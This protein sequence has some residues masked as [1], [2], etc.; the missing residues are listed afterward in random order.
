MSVLA[1]TPQYICVEEVEVEV[2]GDKDVLA[3]EYWNNKLFNEILHVFM[4]NTF[5]E[6]LYKRSKF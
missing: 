5:F 6:I 3:G 1:H 4:I 2:E